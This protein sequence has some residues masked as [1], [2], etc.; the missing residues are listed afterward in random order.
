MLSLI[1]CLTMNIVRM[2]RLKIFFNRCLNSLDVIN[3]ARVLAT[4]NLTNSG[5]ANRWEER[6]AQSTV[7]RHRRPRST[8]WSRLGKFEAGLPCWSNPMNQKCPLNTNVNRFVCGTVK[9]WDFT[10]FTTIVINFSYSTQLSNFD[11]EDLRQMLL[12]CF[13]Y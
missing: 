10:S 13:I 6:P 9:L 2:S 1:I 11:L 4:T 7:D 3:S 12:F 5:L 8:G